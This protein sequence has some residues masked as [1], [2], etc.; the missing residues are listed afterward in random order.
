MDHKRGQRYRRPS[1]CKEGW[2][3]LHCILHLENKKCKDLWG[4]NPASDWY[5]QIYQNSS[6]QN[7]SCIF[8]KPPRAM[9]GAIFFSILWIFGNNLLLCLHS[10]FFGNN[11]L[12]IFALKVAPMPCSF[13]T[14]NNFLL[15]YYSI[16]TF[17]EE[18]S[19]QNFNLNMAEKKMDRGKIWNSSPAL[20][21][22][23]SFIYISIMFR[24]LI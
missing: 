19:I 8:S 22:D 21:L 9:N 4:Q 6:I 10:Y 13:H 7:P 14:L 1:Y 15:C 5:H 3:C 20:I 12:L 16:D 11:L 24:V 23:Q 18:I 17:Y 2:V